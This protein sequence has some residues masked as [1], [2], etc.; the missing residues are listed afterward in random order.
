MPKMDLDLET[1]IRGVYGKPWSKRA[2]ERIQLTRED[3]HLLGKTMVDCIVYEAKKDLAKQGKSPTPRGEPAGLPTSDSFF[4]SF[5]YRIKGRSTVEITS[6]WP[7]IEEHI[8]G[9]E[10]FVM[11]WLTRQNNVHKVPIVQSDGTVIVRTAPLTTANAWIHPGFARHT[12]LER[13]VRAGKKKAAE[14]VAKRAIE[15]IFTKGSPG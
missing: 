6:S 14:I 7:W 5:G 8:E 12:F 15:D 13:G 4:E 3:L 10:S 9:K 1:R 11:K 2:G